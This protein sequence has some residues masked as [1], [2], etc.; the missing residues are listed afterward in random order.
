MQRRNFIQ[1]TSL[2]L[3]SIPFHSFGNNITS[4]K[5]KKVIIIGAGMAG[6]AAAR[7]LTDAGCEVIVLEARNRVG[8]RIHTHTDWGFNIELGANWIHNAYDPENPLMNYA[9]QLN[10]STHKTSYSNLKVYDKEGDKIGGL[11]LAL[12]YQ[13]F[14]KMLGSQSA[15]INQGESDISIKQA[16]HQIIKG[17]NYT[18]REQSIISLIE[19]SYANN[20]AANV[21]KASAS[22]YLKKSVRE[23][24]SDFFVSG[25]Y[26][27][28]VKSLLQHVDVQLNSEIIEIRNH[29]N[30]VEVITEKQAFE[31]DYVIVTVPISILQKQ[32]II[33]NPQLPE[34]K[35][36]SFS[37]MQM[38]VFNKVIMEFT[39]KFWQGNADFQCYNTT[40]GNAFGIAVNYHHYQEKP[41]LI[42]MPVDSAG[43]WVEQNNMD[44]I[45]NTW[46]HILHKAHPGKDI[47]FKNMMITKW[48]A[49]EYAQ[50]SYSHVPVGTTESDFEDL[51]REVGSLHFAGEAT[52]IKQHGTVQGA[53]N[54]GIREA[55]K[56]LN[57]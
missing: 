22:Y 14:E 20:L 34:W 47:E 50:G 26:E 49:D 24:Q 19:E 38:G 10:I 40:L 8:G 1:L 7:K 32:K 31:G 45:K 21:E 35:T 46:Q 18:P 5:S 15:L 3:L 48:N 41:L 42:A 28:I 30:K 54:S 52:N 17:K 56:I 2:G 37:K 29:T 6:A 33:F 23:E 4:G 57:Y 25:G 55:L 43:L 16:I 44:M 51:K 13:H 9:H 11:R 36:Q 53:F 39:E 27:G 12:F